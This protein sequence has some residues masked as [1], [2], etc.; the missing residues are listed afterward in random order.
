MRE[1]IHI[2]NFKNKSNRV[3][4]GSEAKIFIDG[5]EIGLFTGVDFAP[6][7]DFTAIHTLGNSCPEEIVPLNIDC[8]ID[9]PKGLEIDIE[10]INALGLSIEPDGTVL[11]NGE[12]CK[13]TEDIEKSPFEECLF[14]SS[15]SSI[16]QQTEP[17][18]LEALREAME[19]ACLIVERSISDY[20][21]FLPLKLDTD[22][23]R[24]EI[25]NNEFRVD[26]NWIHNQS[27]EFIPI[28]ISIGGEEVVSLQ[29]P[30]L[31]IGNFK[32]NK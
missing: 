19:E 3:F 2:G 21:G 8:N 11:V 1:L 4:S 22:S 28:N 15:I 9:L 25:V 12:E 26:T 29:Q 13:V 10:R 16:D 31:H 32:D 24:S 5:K 14:G 30:L 20:F 23:I 7:R 27:I 17:L 6:E 18:T